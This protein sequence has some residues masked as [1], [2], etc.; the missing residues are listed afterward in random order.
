[1][2]TYESHVFSNGAVPNHLVYEIEPSA[3]PGGEP[4]DRVS[5]APLPPETA[6]R[7]LLATPPA[8]GHSDTA[9]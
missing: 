6:L 8:Q 3:A 7:A 1:M 9:D 2:V 5:L 4:S